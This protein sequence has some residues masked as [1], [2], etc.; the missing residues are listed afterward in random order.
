MIGDCSAYIMCVEGEPFPHR[1]ANG[2]SFDPVDL[3]CE[4]SEDVTCAWCKYLYFVVNPKIDCNKAKFH[5]SL[6][7]QIAKG[8]FLTPYVQILKI[9]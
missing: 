6:W 7:K 5:A 2:T 8:M 3:R 4:L 1:C 9:K